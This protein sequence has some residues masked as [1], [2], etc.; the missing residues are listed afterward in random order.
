MLPADEAS[1]EQAFASVCKRLKLR[2][3]DDRLAW[4]AKETAN[5]LGGTSE[6]TQDSRDLLTERG[7]LLALKRQLSQK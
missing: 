2:A 4:I 7:E 5:T 1:L 3:V 6:L